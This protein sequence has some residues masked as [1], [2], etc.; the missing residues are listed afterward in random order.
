MLEVFGLDSVSE[1]VYREM[2]AHPDDGVRE[3]CDRLNLSDSAVRATLD[4][5][6]EMTLV[7]PASG[8]ARRMHAVRPHLAMEI[9]L[10]QKEAELAAHQQQLEESRAVAVKLISEFTNRG[11]EPPAGDVEHLRGLDHIRD[12]LAVMNKTVKSELMTFAPGGSQT[13]EN[14]RSSRP[15]TQEL[16]AQ[17]VAIRTIYLLSLRNDQATMAHAEWLTS[18]G[19]EVRAVPTLPNRMIIADSRVAIIAVDSEDTADG[20]IVIRTP[21]VVSTLCSLF[22]MMWQAAE[23]LSSLA[24]GRSSSEKLTAQQREALRLLARG[25]TDETIA[26]RLGV[27]PRTARRISTALIAHLNA[28]SRFQA[29]VH[30]AQRGLV[31][32]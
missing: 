1:A 25:A 26:K 29:G 18:V 4:R 14:M 13:P 23:P 16:L 22:E 8:N 9:L 2:L 30:A 11:S 32:H 31:P 19:A 24:G 3:L 27:S 20:A 15:L 7:R 21:G 17:G 12:H 10:A 28:R 5:L 6:S